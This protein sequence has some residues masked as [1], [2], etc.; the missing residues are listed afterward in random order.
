M[1]NI[2][3]IK[4][5]LDEITTLFE[6]GGDNLRFD[7]ATS[8]EISRKLTELKDFTSELQKS[9]EKQSKQGKL[10]HAEE[11]MLKP[12]VDDI[13]STSI[14]KINRGAKPTQEIYN[15][16]A[17]TEIT[18]EHWLGEFGTSKSKDV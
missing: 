5:K 7:K 6:S 14:A 9:L 10:T 3:I 16:I 15:H 11:T 12:A 17:D 8:Q 13:Y 4:S 18:L 1:N 2:L